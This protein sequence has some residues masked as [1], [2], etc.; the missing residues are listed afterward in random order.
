MALKTVVEVEVDTSKFDKW[1]NGT[2]N[3]TVTPGGG[4]PLPGNSPGN[5]SPSLD[6]ERR[7]QS[8]FWRDMEKSGRSFADHLTNATKSL[9]KWTA[10]LALAGGYGFGRL[11]SSVENTVYQ[12]RG[13]GSDYGKYQAFITNAKTLHQDPNALLGKVQEARTDFGK[14][15]SLLGAGK[16]TNEEIR[17]KDTETLTQALIPKFWDFVQMHK[18]DAQPMTQQGLEA[19]QW[20]QFFNIED[21]QRYA[22]ITKEQIDLMQ[23]NIEADEKELEIS[24]KTATAYIN[25]NRAVDRAWMQIEKTFV[26]SLDPLAPELGRLTAAVTSTIKDVFGSQ[27]FKDGI[28]AA[29]QGIEDLGHWLSSP[30]FKEGVKSFVDFLSNPTLAQFLTAVTPENPDAAY[31]QAANDTGDLL[32]ALGGGFWEGVKKSAL[33]DKWNEWFKPSEGLGEH[34]KSVHSSMIDRLRERLGWDNDNPIS[35]FFGGGDDKAVINARQYLRIADPKIDAENA[36]MLAAISGAENQKGDPKLINSAAKTHATGLWQQQPG[37][38]SRFGGKDRFDPKQQAEVEL[39]YQQEYLQHVGGQGNAAEFLLYHLLGQ[40]NFDTV[41]KNHPQ[42]WEQYELKTNPEY[43]YLHKG[44]TDRLSAQV[45]AK[46]PLN[47]VQIT[48]NNNSSADVSLQTNKAS[49]GVN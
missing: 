40:G 33:G 30:D 14:Q 36:A 6:R 26:T 32:G 18:S 21:F 35:D 5:T 38:F 25:L 3:A 46:T 11:S 42:D 12:A 23:S 24:D 41:K 19:N 20:S 17:Q 31:D 8:A 37:M 9:A 29:A 10:G 49:Q 7:K 13:F 16:F 47:N 39:K 34:A 15:S 27:N 48:I 22:K 2:H 28:H 4:S 44:T 1:L 43:R 45:G